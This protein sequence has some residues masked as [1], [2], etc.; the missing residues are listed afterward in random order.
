MNEIGRAGN[1]FLATL[2]PSSSDTHALRSYVLVHLLLV[3]AVLVT[4]AWLLQ[5]GPLDMALAGL[6]SDAATHSFA[7]RHS[8]WLDVLG[9][10]A[11]RGLPILV[12]GVALAAALASFA[13]HDLRQW[14]ALLLTLGA[15]MIAGPLLIGVLKTMTSQHCPA[16][17]Q[18]FGGIVSHAADL[19][20]P[21]WAASRE[22][23]GR[24]MPSGHAGGG[25]ALLSLYFAGWAARRPSW[26]WH[27]LAIGIAAGLLFSVVRMMQGAHFA[28]ATVWSAAIDWTICA[29]CF[30]PLIFPRGS[31]P[32]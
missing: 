16:D 29:L 26:R 9:H 7:W 11:A 5:H 23:A 1:G 20:A 18:E 24:C 3:P 14:R 4:C 12:G 31:T 15:T 19:A 8:V 2:P 30:L 17:L 27:G 25:Y 10:Q 13:F 28:S 21:F 6:F 32:R 22:S